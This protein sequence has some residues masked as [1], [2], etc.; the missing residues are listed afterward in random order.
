MSVKILLEE[1][2]F[3]IVEKQAGIPTQPLR[4]HAEPTL[5]DLLAIQFPELKNVGGLDTGAVHRLDRDTSGLV[6]FARNDE[7][8]EILREAFARNEVEK[9]YV[10]LVQG[11]VIEAGKIDVPI[12]SDP[13]SEKKVR[14]YRNV[15][16]ARRHKAQDALTTYVPVGVGIKRARRDDTDATTLLRVTIKTGRRHQ[17]RVHLAALGHPIV[18]DTLYGARP[19]DRLYLHATRL[20]FRYPQHPQLHLEAARWVEAASPVPFVGATLA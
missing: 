12:G 16:E 8:Y 2:D 10:A 13:K 17:I 6:V 7:T 15:A 18:G 5:A 11:D 9:D 19:S 14:I 3:L 20:K 1:P 4:G